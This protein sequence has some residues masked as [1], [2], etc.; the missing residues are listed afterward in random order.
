MMRGVRAAVWCA[1]L[2]LA[3]S[4]TTFAQYE[5]PKRLLRWSYWSI[6]VGPADHVYRASEYGTERFSIETERITT[7]QLPLAMRVVATAGKT[8]TA[9]RFTLTIGLL[10]ADVD[11]IRAGLQRRP[12]WNGNARCVAQGPDGSLLNWCRMGPQGGLQC[13]ILGGEYFDPQVIITEI[14]QHGKWVMVTGT[15]TG[16]SRNGL[17]FN[18]GH[19]FLPIPVEWFR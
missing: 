3:V 16:T 7:S 11:S 5:L 2:L 8:P 4:G 9:G 15:C 14:R 19:F 6:R 13:E 12:F 17:P 10:P 18:E 1:V